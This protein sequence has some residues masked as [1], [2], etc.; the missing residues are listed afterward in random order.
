MFARRDTDKD[1]KLTKEEFLREQPDAKDAP[2]R[3]T[4]F[5]KNSDGVLSKEEFIQGGTA[6]AK[7]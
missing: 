1:G 5:D 7:E 6:P 2:A 3:F 4:R